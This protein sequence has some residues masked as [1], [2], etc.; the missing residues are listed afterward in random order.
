M[1][2]FKIYKGL[3][4]ASNYE[5]NFNNICNS[6]DFKTYITKVHGICPSGLT[7]SCWAEDDGSL[8]FMPEI[9]YYGYNSSSN[10]GTAYSDLCDYEYGPVVDEKY[11]STILMYFKENYPDVYKVLRGHF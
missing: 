8:R 2:D 11:Y 1:K 5:V 10:N 9:K 4:R 7:I 6:F 3:D